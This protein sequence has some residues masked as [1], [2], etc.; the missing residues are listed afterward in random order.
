MTRAE[1]IMIQIRQSVL[2]CFLFFCIHCG[3]PRP[4]RGDKSRRGPAIRTLEPSTSR[5]HQTSQSTYRQ[6][7]SHTNYLNNAN[8]GPC[9]PS[10]CRPPVFPSILIQDGLVHRSKC[11]LPEACI[12]DNPCTECL[13]VQQTTRMQP[14]TRTLACERMC[15]MGR[16]CSYLFTSWLNGGAYLQSIY[17]LVSVY[18]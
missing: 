5:Y 12:P 13:L 8:Q 1:A 9:L 15:F 10:S 16:F 17:L 11:V 2:S 4:A 18:A 14:G 6:P 3:T 7:L